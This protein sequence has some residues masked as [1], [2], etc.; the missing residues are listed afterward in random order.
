MFLIKAPIWFAVL[1]GEFC[2]IF[3]VSSSVKNAKG[4]KIKLK[5]NKAKGHSDRVL[6]VLK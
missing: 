1:K 4:Q 5:K 2:V 6:Q 3:Q